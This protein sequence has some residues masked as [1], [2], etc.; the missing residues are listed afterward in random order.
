[1]WSDFKEWRSDGKVS[2]T[3]QVKI[4]FVGESAM[5][6]RCPKR[7]FFSG[8]IKVMSILQGGPAPSIINFD[9]YKYLTKQILRTEGMTVSK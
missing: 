1:M 6:N 4:V 2:P 8:E 3:D 9:V 7:E 5:D